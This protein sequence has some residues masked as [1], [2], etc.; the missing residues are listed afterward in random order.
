MRDVVRFAYVRSNGRTAP[1][2]ARP[3]ESPPHSA[4]VCALAHRLNDPFLRFWFRYVYPNRSALEAG[5]SRQVLET[6]VLRDL[7]TFMGGPFEDICRQR[8]IADGQ[9]RLGWQPVRICRYWD[10][11]TEIDLIAV[12]A[13]GDRV[14][15][16]ECQWGRTVDVTRTVRRLREKARTVGL[17]A[18]ASHQYLVISRTDTENE[19]HVRLA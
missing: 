5:A 2:V 17:F 7:D 4:A 16:V 6:V 10:A 12:D 19:H 8:L 1:A 3:P 13:T 15:F 9:R 14:A 11:R 18:A